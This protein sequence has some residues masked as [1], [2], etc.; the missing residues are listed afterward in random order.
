MPGPTRPPSL[1]P[2]AL[3][4]F[5][6]ELAA[7]VALLLA[8]AAACWW[9]ARRSSNRR[10][11]LALQRKNQ[12]LERA[13]EAAQEATELKSLF[14]ANMSHEI[15]TPIHGVLGMT[16]L[17]LCTRLDAEQREYADAVRRSAQS[18]LA[19]INDILDLSKIEAGKLELEC[20]RF[21]LWRTVEEVAALMAFRACGKNLE[22]TCLIQPDV[23]HLVR[24][25]P[26]RLRQ[27]L[28]NLAGNAVKFTERG[29]VGIRVESSAEA[30]GR[31]VVRFS[32]A[33]T[34]VGIAPEQ[35]ERLFHSFTQGDLST[36]RRYGGTGLGLAI[37]RCLAERMGG[38]VGFESQLGEG[39]T[40]WFTASFER[41]TG[42]PSAEPP[43][44]FSALRV[45]V[46]D[47]KATSRM[48]VQ[49]Y[50][51]SWGCRTEECGEAGEAVARMLEAAARDDPFRVAIVDLHMPE[52][53]GAWL[54]GQVKEEP[55]LRGAHLLALTPV[56]MVGESARLRE[57][58][59][60]A[61]LPKPVR[62][63]QLY[64]RLLETLQPP[65]EPVVE[66]VRPAFARPGR[67][68]LLAE[69][70]EINQKIVLRL[71]A[72]AGC[73]AERVANG[74]EAVEAASRSAWDLILMDVQMPEMDGFTATAEI[75]KQ[76][77]GA[78]HTPIAAMTANAMTGDREKCLA[79]GM[80]DYIS[81][82][83]RL[84]DLERMLNR[85]LS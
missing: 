75:R 76:E 36:T 60:A 11:A 40:F 38:G 43:G 14:L 37:S 4:S 64:G 32:V 53:D 79:A 7:G 85:W 42:A 33:D 10:Y 30:H 61:H 45:L 25:D 50:L 67:R 80:D 65:L 8:A 70:N 56:G 55:R 46:V 49:R 22:L 19:V 39:S 44:V 57:C 48:V 1:L 27:V 54:A 81:K 17:L 84:E 41:E 68:V 20:I 78:R 15:R 47:D 26:S 74:R 18:L 83:V 66:P 52:R 82:P 31:A 28:T 24:G 77:E 29:E 71:L 2:I 6:P 12:E 51:E 9:L 62:P 59:F 58:G 23:P 72:R 63:S 34:G 73:R 3:L 16:E 35:R 5:L 13:L 69:D 21:D